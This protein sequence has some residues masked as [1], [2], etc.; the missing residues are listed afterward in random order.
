MSREGEYI[1]SAVVHPRTCG[2]HTSRSPRPVPVSGS[3]PHVR[4]T[5]ISRCNS[6]PYPRFIPARAGNILPGLSG[7]IRKTVHP[8][9]C[10]EHLHLPQ[11]KTTFNGSSPHVRGT[12]HSDLHHDRHC[13]FIPARAGNIGD[14]RGRVP[15][16]S[17]HPRTCGEHAKLQRPATPSGGSSPHVRGTCRISQHDRFDRRFI[18]ARAGNIIARV[19]LH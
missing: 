11:F 5:F 13:R 1:V 15:R 14:R 12:F 6:C 2:E 10:G 17:V 18:P 8:R 16:R 4:G 9:T 7:Q 3:S 19:S